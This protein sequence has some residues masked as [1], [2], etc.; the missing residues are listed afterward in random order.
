MYF[1]HLPHHLS[2]GD[3]DASAKT[4]IGMS[5]EKDDVRFL[6]AVNEMIFSTKVA[7]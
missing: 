2:G 4:L 5:L 6:I 7:C 3:V 1:K